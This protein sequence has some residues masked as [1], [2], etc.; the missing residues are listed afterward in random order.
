MTKP[1]SLIPHSRPTLDK[2]DAQAV[3]AVVDSGQLAQGPQVAAF[4]R[5]VAEL[6]GVRGAVAVGSG[7]AAL[8]TALLALGIGPGDEVILPSYVCV[9]P[10]LAV[11]RVGAVPRL[12]DID[13][14][15]YNLDPSAVR[16][17]L[18]PRTRAVIVPH[19]FGLAA[20]L[21]A[22]QLCRFR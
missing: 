15:S 16:Q 3:T 6:V 20:D 17:A 19:L 9:A 13:A 10:W 2:A 21:T 14:A 1:A 12:V 7:T 5:A 11:V 8:T 22:L 18:S 4:E